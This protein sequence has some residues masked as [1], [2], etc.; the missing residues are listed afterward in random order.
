MNSASVPR[1]AS[2]PCC[3]EAHARGAILTGF[4]RNTDHDIRLGGLATGIGGA[5]LALVVAVRMNLSEMEEV[6]RA[7]SLRLCLSPFV[8]LCTSLASG[9]RR[10]RCGAG[11]VPDS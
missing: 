4:P 7:A 8:Y 10:R 9:S 2:R 6:V 3:H 11:L 1:T 5:H